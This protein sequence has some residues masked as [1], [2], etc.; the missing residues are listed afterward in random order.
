M[1]AWGITDVGIVRSA[2]PNEDAYL[3]KHLGK[4]SL[5]AVVCDGMGGAN[6][7]EVASAIAIDVFRKY[8]ESTGQCE[9]AL[10]GKEHLTKVIGEANRA[11]FE[12]SLKD[13]EL[14]GM[15][16]TVVAVIC[17]DNMAVLANV[18]DSR[19]YHITEDGITHITTDHS[20]VSEMLRKGEISQIDAH[21]H[22]SRNLITRALGVDPEVLCDTYFCPVKKGDYILL[23][24][25]GLNDQVSEPEIYYEVFESGHPEKAGENLVAVANSRGGSDNI[26]II[27]IAF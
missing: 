27:L 23:C 25:D 20:L 17:R 7:G 10:K 16:T 1:E 21:R 22:P 18:G 13:D 8:F 24:S 3:V 5:L 15:G 12:A 4:D 9:S 2:S 19:G 26:T 14:T 6:A 11:V